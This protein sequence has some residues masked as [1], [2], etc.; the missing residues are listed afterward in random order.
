MKTN[1]KEFLNE[2]VSELKIKKGDEVEV[3][4]E[5][6]EGSPKYTVEAKNDSWIHEG[7]EMFIY[8]TGG[9]MMMI[10]EWDGDN[11]TTK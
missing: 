6:Y 5:M 1:F 7:S 3:I 2:N 9:D 8:L 4:M 10:A 11:W